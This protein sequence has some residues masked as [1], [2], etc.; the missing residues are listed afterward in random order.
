M[1]SR[2]EATDRLRREGRW[3]AASHAREEKRQQLRAEGLKRADANDQAWRWMIDEFT[4]LADDEIRID[5]S[6]NLAAMAH[7]PPKCDGID[8]DGEAAMSDIWWVLS[9]LLAWRSQWD[10]GRCS[11]GER[12]IVSML[13]QAPTPGASRLGLLLV[14]SPARF[15]AQA[16]AKLVS[17]HD[18][19]ANDIHPPAEYMAEIDWHIANL[20]E[21][22][23]LF[24]G[25]LPVYVDDE[26]AAPDQ[27]RETPPIRQSRAGAG[28]T[29]LAPVSS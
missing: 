16:Y 20:L 14:E 9:H 19:W 21:L 17:V 13:M 27:A 25:A 26:E 6:C 12:F 29:A 5:E 10:Q 2:I 22:Q 11:I 1:E 4:P 28:V 8:A 23:S 15:C 24:D 3:E 18:R 7:Y